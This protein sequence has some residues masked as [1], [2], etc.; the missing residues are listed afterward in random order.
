MVNYIFTYG[1]LINIKYSKELDKND[2]RIIIPV[3]IN[4]IQRHWI[5]CKNSK[6]YLGIKHDDKSKTNGLIIE[7]SDN[8]LKRLDQ[9]EK[10]YNRINLNWNQIEYKYDLDMKDLTAKLNPKNITYNKLTE[11][12][13]LFTYYP[14]PLQ[15]MYYIF[16]KS[17]EQC[18]NYL[19]ICLSGCLKVS[20]KFFI[21][22][23]LTTRG[24]S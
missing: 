5:Y 9:R 12:D 8:E 10:Y 15:S 14:D 3:S 2:N 7:V 1:S 20:H 21:D 24:W 17:S 16:N 22:F 18:Q 13:N 23:L 6:T 19:I 11:L 4:K